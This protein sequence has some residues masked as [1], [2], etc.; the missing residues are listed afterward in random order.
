MT[1]VTKMSVY[2]PMSDEGRADS[3][4]GVGDWLALSDEERHA[5]KLAAQME[6]AADRERA[7]DPVPL[8][9]GRLLTKLGFTVAYAQH[10]VQPYCDCADTAD[11][12]SECAHARDLGLTQ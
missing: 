9:L 2:I 11:G 4:A 1:D 3:E 8:T 6:R 12:W 7:G 10:L 5:R